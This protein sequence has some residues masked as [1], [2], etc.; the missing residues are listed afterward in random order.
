VYFF[1]KILFKVE[2]KRI[3]NKSELKLREKARR[4]KERGKRIKGT[5]V[6]FAPV[7]QK[8]K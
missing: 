4:Y 6:K 2:G 8:N 5:P 1:R 3:K 7:K